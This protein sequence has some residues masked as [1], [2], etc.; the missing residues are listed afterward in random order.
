MH[1]YPDK[2]AFPNEHFP[3]GQRPDLFDE[4]ERSA[5]RR[6]NAPGKPDL[7]EAFEACAE[8]IKKE[9]EAVKGDLPSDY[10]QRRP[11]I[12]TVVYIQ[13]SPGIETYWVKAY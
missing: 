6:A 3:D 11:P 9:L 2:S 1:E 7:R 12:R 5:I 4:D 10:F 13:I 8:E